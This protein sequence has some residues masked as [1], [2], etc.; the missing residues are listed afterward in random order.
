MKNFKDKVC[1][2]CNKPYTPIGSSSKYCKPCGDKYKR[3]K[4][5][6]HQQ[7]YKIRKGLIKNPGVGSGKAQ[8][9]GKEHHSYTTG[10]G[11]TFQDGRHKIKE[12]RRYCERCNEDLINATRH[13][14][15]LH[16]KDHDRTNNVE[17]NFELLCKRCHQVE[18]D[19]QE[20]F[21]K[22]ND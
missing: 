8:G 15:C 7:A 4:M 5:C 21:V 16:H 6:E 14:W 12:D 17:E 18:H 2:I 9:F 19:C 10:I 13:T 1:T 11:C 20:A 3:V 22:C